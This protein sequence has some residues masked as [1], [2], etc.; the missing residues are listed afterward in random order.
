MSFE[1]KIYVGTGKDKDGAEL[2][3]HFVETRLN[4]VRFQLAS[5][6]GGYSEYSHN[7]G[8]IHN[9]QLIQEPGVTFVVVTNE[10]IHDAGIVRFIRDEF[11]Q[12]AVLVT[13]TPVVSE[14]V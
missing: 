13:K 7:G 14:F 9:G 8:W 4:R 11:R 10:E 12:T 6:F 3:P 2:T 1:V 5:E